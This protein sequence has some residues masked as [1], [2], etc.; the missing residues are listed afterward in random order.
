MV[1][2]PIIFERGRILQVYTNRIICNDR[3]FEF[4]LLASLDF[5][6]S[7]VEKSVYE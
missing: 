6:D 7:P 1:S 2:V 3:D 5:T 4:I